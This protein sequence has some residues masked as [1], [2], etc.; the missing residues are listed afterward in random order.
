MIND[1]SE[2]LKK[3][4]EQKKPILARSVVSQLCG[5]PT[6]A[7]RRYERGEADPSIE[8]LIRLADFY[9]VSIDY[10]LGRVPYR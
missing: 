5:L 4:R 9:E 6:D 8:S 1:F 10:L 3:L 2:R 7:V